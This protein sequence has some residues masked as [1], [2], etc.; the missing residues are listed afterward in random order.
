MTSAPRRT[1]AI[2]C[3]AIAFVAGLVGVESVYGQT[4]PGAPDLIV[5]NAKVVTVDGDFSTAEAFAVRDG[6]F[7]SVGT[8]AD[9]LA[10]A[11]PNTR[12]VDMHGRTILPGFND[13]HVHITSGRNLEVQVNLTDIHSIQ[14]IQNAISARVAQSQPGEWIVG[15]RGWWEYDLSDG[16]LPTRADLDAVAPNNP[17][18][19]PGPHYTIVNSLALRLAGITRDTPDPQGGEIWK[20]P[21]TGEPTG[22]L[23]DNAS[24]AVRRFYPEPTREQQ[25]AGLRRVL[26]LVNS[27][28]LTSVGDPGGSPED[29]A[30]FRE[31]HGNN[32]LTVRLDFSYSVDPAAPLDQIEAELRSFPQPGWNS[33]D[34]MIR[35]DQLGETG[36]DGAE[37]TALL[38]HDYPTRPGYRGLQKVPQEQF[39]RFAALVNRYGWRLRPHAVG[40]GAIDEALHAF[41]FANRERSIVGRR[42]MIDHAF[43]LLPRHYADVRRLGLIINSQ[44]MH[45]YQLGALILRAW[46]RPL[47]DQS[48]MFGD[49][50]RNGIMFANGSDGPISYHAEPLLEIYG[51]VTRNTGWGG[52]L[53]PTQG[54]SR[55]DAIRSVTINGAHTSFEENVKGSIEEGKYADFVVLSGDIMTVPADQIRDLSVLATVLGGRAVYGDVEALGRSQP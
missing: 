13:T 43:L 40:D 48:E 32:Q 20:D 31:L 54:I 50:V 42:W 16:R 46:E 36:L 47:A 15:T 8:N 29:M 22:L 52:Q 6:R 38:S 10:T 41:E 53:G 30:L 27:H 37:L 49:W 39:D 18:A 19:I 23:M 11:G 12:R 2:A 1:L 7:V 26:A 28:G 14:D 21:Q 45:N 34:G 33:G 51:S 25:L 9:V 4:P 44:Y 17:V 55:E 35:S 5:H 24:R 3:A